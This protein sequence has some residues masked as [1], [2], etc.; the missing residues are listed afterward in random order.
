MVNFIILVV[1]QYTMRDC[2]LLIVAFQ[3]F[4]LMINSVALLGQNS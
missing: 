2:T 1:L 3:C 4:S